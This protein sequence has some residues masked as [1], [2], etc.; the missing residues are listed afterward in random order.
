MYISKLEGAQTAE[1]Q[2]QESKLFNLLVESMNG[3]P[4]LDFGT[5]N[6]VNSNLKGYEL[7]INNHTVSVDSMERKLSLQTHVE[8]YDI[9]YS[10]GV[11]ILVI[12]QIDVLGNLMSFHVES[13]NQF[14]ESFKNYIGRIEDKSHRLTCEKHK[15]INRIS[16]IKP[17]SGN[18]FGQNKR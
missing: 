7:K 8:Q 11:R 18:P 4:G 6:P 13:V 5:E 17:R 12:S 2:N 16:Q 15:T 3:K 10:K 1:K 9:Y 14:A